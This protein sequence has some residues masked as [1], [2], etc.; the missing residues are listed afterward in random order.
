MA[1]PSWAGEGFSSGCLPG[2]QTLQTLGPSAG[3]GRESRDLPHMLSPRHQLQALVISTSQE[4]QS[5]KPPDQRQMS[6]S[7]GRVLPGLWGGPL[8]PSPTIPRWPLRPR[9]HSIR[10]LPSS[11]PLP[12]TMST[13]SFTGS[14]S[15]LEKS[16]WTFTG[17]RTRAWSSTYRRVVTTSG[18]GCSA[19]LLPGESPP[20]W[21][22]GLGM[23]I[24]LCGGFLGTCSHPHASDGT[25]GLR[26]RLGTL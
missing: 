17:F 9:T 3:E 12:S 21:P 16:I 11:R 2:S 7:T 13:Q 8:G 20:G 19:H 10:R 26:G 18:P 15:G 23:G 22:G 14:S 25:P 24:H 1:L 5:S 6:T 4:F